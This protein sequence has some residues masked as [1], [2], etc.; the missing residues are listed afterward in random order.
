[1]RRELLLLTCLLLCGCNGDDSAPSPPTSNYPTYP[2]YTGLPNPIPSQYYGSCT[3]RTY[4]VGTAE[5][6]EED[7]RYWA[8]GC[9]RMCHDLYFRKPWDT[10]PKY[11]AHPYNNCTAACNAEHQRQHSRC[12]GLPRYRPYNQLSVPPAFQPPLVAPQLP[13]P[14]PPLTAPL[15]PPL[16]PLGAPPPPPPPPPLGAPMHPPPP[17]QLPPPQ[18]PP[19]MDAR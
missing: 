15:P 2:P 13:P 1:V 10:N 18:P 6:C 12:S 14:P 19:L 17:R 5:A 9:E 7:A 4:P 16:P 8:C 3:K 11:D